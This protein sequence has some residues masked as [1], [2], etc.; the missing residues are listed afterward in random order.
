MKGYRQK[1]YLLFLSGALIAAI[2]GCSVFHSSV[3]H[4][5]W[6]DY[7]AS[8]IQVN[9]SIPQDSTILSIL[10]PYK[11]HVHEVMDKIVGFSDGDFVKGKPDG[12]LGNLV[13]DAVRIAAGNIVGKAINIGVI[14]NSSIQSQ[15]KPGKITRNT[16]YHIMPY[17]NHLVILKLRGSQVR[18]MANEIANVGGEPI[19]GMRMSIIDGEA[20]AI[21]VGNHVIQDDSLYT[22]ATNN[23][24][25]DG[26]G[27]LSAVWKP[28]ERKDLSLSIRKAISDYISD[29]INVRPV[30]DGRIR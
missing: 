7:Q 24:M 10:A 4:Y 2:S 12:T 1:L 25:A 26:G 14:T 20:Q 6:N 29:R 28:V 3:R 23:Y 22:V 8:N 16:V 9:S 19:S 21:L 11:K 18:E 5:K 30:N 17:N 27:D 13:A 15:I